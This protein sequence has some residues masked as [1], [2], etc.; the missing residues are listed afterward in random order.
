MLVRKNISV[1][2]SLQ[3]MELEGLNEDVNAA[4]FTW[5]Y[6]S[7]QDWNS[8]WY[9]LLV[10]VRATDGMLETTGTI[11]IHVRALNDPPAISLGNSTFVTQRI[12][13]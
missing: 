11:N 9:G 1:S 10:A 6:Q 12:M 2:E 4:L 7:M 8:E 5:N 3:K 13:L